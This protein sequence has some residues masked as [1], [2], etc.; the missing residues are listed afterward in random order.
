MSA[1]ADVPRSN[2][3]HEMARLLVQF[4]RRIDDLERQVASLRGDVSPWAMAAT[5]PPHSVSTSTA[6]AVANRCQFVRSTGRKYGATQLQIW[7]G[8]AS[9]NISVAVYASSGI[10]DAAVPTD[11]KATTGAIA[12]P[13]AGLAVVTLTTAVDVD[14]GDFM[15]ISADNTVATFGR[16]ASGITAQGVCWRMDTAHPAP[17][18]AGSLFADASGFYVSTR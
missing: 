18:A 4:Q 6:V 8:T 14:P 3:D 5:M 1:R 12:C 11:R 16:S 10:G 13:A 9:G 15:A 17:A 7:V 2:P